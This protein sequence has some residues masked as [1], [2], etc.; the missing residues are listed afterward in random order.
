[1]KNLL[2]I[3]FLTAIANEIFAT[4]FKSVK[5]PKIETDIYEI[6]EGKI[7]HKTTG[8]TIQFDGTQ[9]KWLSSTNGTDLK[10]IGSGS[11]TGSIGINAFTDSQ[12][13]NAED[14]IAG[15]TASNPAT[16]SVIDKN[17]VDSKKVIEGDKTFRFSPT[18]QNDFAKSSL[19]SL[20]F[21]K[22]YNR[23][24]EAGIE[25]TGGD[26]NLEIHVIDGTGSILNE[27]IPANRKIIA[28]PDTTGSFSVKFRC[29][30]LVEVL[31]NGAKGQVEFVIKNVGAQVSQVIEWD[32]TYLG[33]Y[34]TLTDGSYQGVVLNSYATQTQTQV[35]SES[36][37]IN[38]VGTPT[39]ENDLC[40][41]WLSNISDNAVGDWVLNFLP[42]IFNQAPLC[43]V[44]SG[45]NVA[46]AIVSDETA[47][48]V[49]VR[50]YDSASQIP[51]DSR[52]IIE[53]KGIK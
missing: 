26:E 3:I 4:T 18:A 7:K 2:L 36:C 33:T 28:R 13:P 47:T 49:R 31:G 42:S 41:Y 19:I 35:R 21:Y 14:G 48:S 5:A 6:S 29:P 12:N 23:N 45:G 8:A 10:K 43:E 11:G 24:C 30:T 38:G 46:A 44:T 50:L 40:L 20:D 32:L 9:N 16:L 34:R 27:D 1:M 25:Y 39:T 53:C 17:G 37:K 15:W 51:V 52:F 22:F